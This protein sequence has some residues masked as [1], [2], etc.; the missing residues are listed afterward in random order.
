MKFLKAFV[1]NWVKN[2]KHNKKE[3]YYNQPGWFKTG[4]D[5]SHYREQLNKIN[6]YNLIDYFILAWNIKYDFSFFLFQYECI[7][8]SDI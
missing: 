8:W 3:I 7:F 4:V 5:K 6:L 1:I 2:K